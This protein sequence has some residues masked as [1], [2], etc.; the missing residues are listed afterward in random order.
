MARLLDRDVVPTDADFE[1]AAGPHT[2]LWYRCRDTVT[3]AM[4]A[5]ADTV[6]GGR[7]DGWMLRVR[8]AGRP[9]TT[10]APRDV[11]FNAL[12]ILGSADLAGAEALPLSPRVRAVLDSARRY[13][14]GTWLFIP[15]E[16][17]SDVD[18]VVGLLTLKLPARVR[19]RLDSAA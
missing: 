5:T 15:V 14:D 2:D 8:R 18:D 7:N 16:V 9:F 17:A 10:L 13:P 3:R 6:W 19:R 4:G 12:V 1:R 11:G